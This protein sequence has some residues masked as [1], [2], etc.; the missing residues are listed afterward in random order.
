[1]DTLDNFMRVTEWI[2]F[3]AHSPGRHFF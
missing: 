3:G 1:M 2:Q